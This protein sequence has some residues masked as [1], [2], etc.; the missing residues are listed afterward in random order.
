MSEWND[1]NIWSEYDY[2]CDLKARTPTKAGWMLLG[3]VI[4]AIFVFAAVMYYA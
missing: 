3:L 1:E 4:V 2:S